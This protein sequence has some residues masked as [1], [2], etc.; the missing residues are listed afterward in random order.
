LEKVAGDM[1]PAM[2]RL[3]DMHDEIDSAIERGDHG[4]ADRL[5]DQADAIYSHLGKMG[6]L[7]S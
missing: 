3:G 1:I 5:L 2:Q 6:D 7:Y 4:E